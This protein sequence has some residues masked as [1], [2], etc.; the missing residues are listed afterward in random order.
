[1]QSNIVLALSLLAFTTAA[2]L[3]AQTQAPAAVPQIRSLSESDIELLSDLVADLPTYRDNPY[4]QD[5]RAAELH[6]AGQAVIGAETDVLLFVR[7]VTRAEVLG[8]IQQFGRARLALVHDTPP[9]FGNLGTWEYE[10]PWKVQYFHPFIS[11]QSLRIGWEIPLETVRKIRRGDVVRIR[12]EVINVRVVTQRSA[13]NPSMS[14]FVGNWKV[15][16]VEQTGF[17]SRY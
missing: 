17:E 10:G 4:M 8:E 13:F 2:P 6:R 3:Y 14:I 11:Q 1:M 5:E 7:R 9:Q 12:G 15:V 16:D